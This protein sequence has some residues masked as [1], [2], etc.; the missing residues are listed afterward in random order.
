[1]GFSDNLGLDEEVE[2]NFNKT[3]ED[4]LRGDMLKEKNHFGLMGSHSQI[5]ESGDSKQRLFYGGQH[6]DEDNFEGESSI[7]LGL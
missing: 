2:Q 7:Y 4:I 6:L 1:M 3:Q 5:K